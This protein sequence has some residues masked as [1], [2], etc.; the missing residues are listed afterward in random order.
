MHVLGASVLGVCQFARSCT[1]FCVCNQLCLFVAAC[2][3]VFVKIVLAMI[4]VSAPLFACSSI[5]VGVAQFAHR[6]PVL[7]ATYMVFPLPE[8]LEAVRG[9]CKLPWAI[10]GRRELGCNRMRM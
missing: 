8:H 6:A 4:V 2:N 5:F 9:F 1:A 10:T 3:V 7:E